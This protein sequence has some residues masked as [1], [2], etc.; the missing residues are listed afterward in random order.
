MQKGGTNTAQG[1]KFLSDAQI[2]EKFNDLFQKNG[3]VFT[4]GS[5][6][7]GTQPTPK[8]TQTLTNVEVSY[9][10]LDVESGEA[11]SGVAAGQ[12]TDTGD[13]GVYKAITGA[14]KYVFMKTFLIPTGDDPE[15]DSKEP[16]ARTTKVV[17]TGA[18]DYD[19]PPFG[20][21]SDEDSD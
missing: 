12:G 9:E 19:K 15:N 6:I 11:I 18:V 1:Y 20:K 16:S 13:K 5:K 10:F 8:N 14:I 17:R 4:Y 21:G 7:T 3:I 2:M